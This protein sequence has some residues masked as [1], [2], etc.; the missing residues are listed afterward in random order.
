MRIVR[1]IFLVLGVLVIAIVITVFGIRFY[2]NQKYDL[3]EKATPDYYDLSY[4][5]DK[6]EGGTI[7]YFEEGKA[8]GFNLLPDNPIDTEIIVVFG[9][10]EGSSNF[11]LSLQLAEEGYE[12]YSLFFFGA[13]NQ[14]E[15]LNQIP[16]EF[17]QD[18]LDYATLNN[19]SVTVIGVSKG[20]ELGLILTNYYDEVANLV[21]YSP[22]S[23]VYQGLSFDRQIKSSWLWKGKELPFINLQQS[24]F[25]DLSKNIIDS[26]LLNPVSYRKTYISAV[27]MNDNSEEAK[28]NTSNFGGQALLIAG[29]K[30]EVWQGDV[31]ARELSKALGGNTILDIYPKAGHLFG[32]PPTIGGMKI[33]GSLEANKKAKKES[34]K[35]LFKFLKETIKD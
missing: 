26:I 29:E 18:F 34:D 4:Y 30:D 32:V 35:R 33:G 9:G 24:S 22:S 21:L 10:S 31:A 17:F 6:F 8:A 11:D 25:G 16:L 1:K 15:E 2:N 7:K 14:N 5:P 13:P 27:E 20:A 23:Y 3:T 12:V 19:K 28:I